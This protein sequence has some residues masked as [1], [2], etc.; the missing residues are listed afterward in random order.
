MENDGLASS[1]SGAAREVESVRHGGSIS[2]GWTAFWCFCGVC[3]VM[4]AVHH[5]DEEKRWVLSATFSLYC[6][7]IGLNPWRS[8]KLLLVGR[9]EPHEATTPK[10]AKP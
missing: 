3:G 4:D 9:S 6:G 1:G 5:P 2:K 8:L 7:L 10:E